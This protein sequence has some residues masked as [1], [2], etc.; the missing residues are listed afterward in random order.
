MT[1]TTLVINCSPAA[2]RSVSRLLLNDLLKQRT[3][4][5][6]AD[7]VV[8]RDLAAMGAALPHVDG[9]FSN[10]IFA[11][12][13]QRSAEQQQGLKLSDEL[14]NE[15]LDAKTIIIATPMYNLSIPSSLKAWIDHV[16]RPG[17]T[18][19]FNAGVQQGLLTGKKAILLCASG[20]VYS[21]GARTAED[22]QVP[23]LRQILRFM[24]ITDVDVYRAEGL[25]QDHEGAVKSA[26]EHLITS[27]SESNY[28]S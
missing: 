8:V 2:E 21:S 22:F 17:L 26:R 6:P 9:V 19:T 25:A 13:P 15:L 27:V 18:F 10:A 1:L 20:G 14:V 24:G 7:R 4:T 28:Q 16:V 23:Y 11:P 12:P 5:H 3:K